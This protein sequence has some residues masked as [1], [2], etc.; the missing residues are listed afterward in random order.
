MNNKRLKKQIVISLAVLVISL[1]FAY[2]CRFEI[3]AGMVRPL[4]NFIAS[5]LNCIV[6]LVPFSLM[7]IVVPAFI[8]GTAVYIIT[9]LAKKKWLEW[10]PK[11]TLSIAYII[12]AYVFFYNY[13][14]SLPYS[15]NALPYTI[16]KHSVDTLIEVTEMLIDDLNNANRK[17]ERDENGEAIFDD[18]RENANKVNEGYRNLMAKYDFTDSWYLGKVKHAGILAEPMAY[19]DINGI[20]FPFIVEANAGSTVNTNYPFI[21]AHEQAHTLGV[22]RENEANFFAFLACLESGDEQLAYSA[23]MMAY[24]YANNAIYRENPEKGYELLMTLDKDVLDDINRLNEHAKKYD[25]PAKEV[26]EKVNDTMLKVNGQED[27]IKTYGYMTD[28]LISYYLSDQE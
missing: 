20:F 14:F 24:V 16:E 10:I 8:L 4:S 6:S 23:Y 19:L 5:G 26:G 2:A 9:C 11:V 22:V 18:F 21:I 28:L 15:S 3:V 7:Q 25:T 12:F 1:I 13:G 27:G 17:L